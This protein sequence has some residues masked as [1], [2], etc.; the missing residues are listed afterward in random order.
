VW[1]CPF[2]SFGSQGTPPFLLYVLFIVV[3]YYSV[4]FF[5]L[6]SLG[7]GRSVQ[8][9][10]LIWPKVVFGSTMCCLA[11]LVVCSSQAGRRWHPA[12]GEPSWFLHLPWSGD[13]MCMLGGVV[14]LDF[15]LFL[16]VFPA[17][18]ISSVSPRF[19]F[20]RHAFC[21]LPLVTILHDLN[22]QVFVDFSNTCSRLIPLL[23]VNI[24]YEF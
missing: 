2:P 16:V 3:V 18:C 5:S 6:F 4:W 23:S 15:Y 14:V 9:A 10:M 7:V 13:A 1:D 8:G 19:Y 24:L 20:R 11:H 17:R 12:A 21:F 22:F